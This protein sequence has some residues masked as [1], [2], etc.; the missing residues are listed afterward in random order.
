MTIRGGV[1]SFP[2]WREC[3]HL[4]AKAMRKLGFP[5]AEVT[6]LGVD[7]GVD[8]RSSVALAQVKA[9]ATATSRP[10]IQ[11]L[12]G[13]TQS[14]KKLGLFFSTGGYTAG[15]IEW[16]NTAGV[17]LF[18]LESSGMIRPIGESAG[19]LLASSGKPSEVT[20]AAPRGIASDS[21]NTFGS[22]DWSQW[23]G[24]LLVHLPT[25]DK[26]SAQGRS[27]ARLV[28]SSCDQPLRII[29]HTGLGSGEGVPIGL[30]QKLDE[31]QVVYLDRVELFPDDKLQILLQVFSGQLE[32]V[33]NEGAYFQSMP[34]FDIAEATS[35][36]SIERERQR[37]HGMQ[38]LVA[39]TGDPWMP[40][41]DSFGA[42]RSL[43]VSAS[44]LTRTGDLAA[45]LTSLGDEGILIVDGIEDL[46]PD[47]S[48]MLV[49]AVR[50]G[51][52]S[53]VVGT[54]SDSRS[55]VIPL[56]ALLVVGLT[57]S[58]DALPQDLRA[59]FGTARQCK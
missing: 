59:A 5:D 36:V 12:H 37:L 41:A 27:L 13:I 33:P 9:R 42:H 21:L 40:H 24:H 39:W 23:D 32:L 29:D 17:A 10:E 48:R 14:E 57:D 45:V 6:A 20:V 38:K 7:G 19:D 49:A 2:H 35:E 31:G 25:G 52:L 18:E 8:V 51:A 53:V 11:Q 44:R 47:V 46:R 30:M 58:P 55:L 15:A 26:A 4:A 28:A 43:I 1:E 16:A 56:P 22:M 54:G 3:E 34:P 50:T